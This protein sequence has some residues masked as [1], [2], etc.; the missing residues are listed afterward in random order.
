MS[1]EG[2][3]AHQATHSS[4][5]S[6]AE[7][8]SPTPMAAVDHLHLTGDAGSEMRTSRSHSCLLIPGTEPYQGERIKR[9]VSWGDFKISEYEL[10]EEEVD[11]KRGNKPTAIAVSFAPNLGAPLPT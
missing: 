2:D 8:P 11:E 5:H 7:S 10:T 9:S 1:G 3:A 4:G 6:L